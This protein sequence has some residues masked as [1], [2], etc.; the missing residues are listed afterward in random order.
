MAGFG[1][2]EEAS[3]I[4]NYAYEN[5]GDFASY[6]DIEFLQNE[7]E[8]PVTG[9]LDP[10]TVLALASTY[11][12]VAGGVKLISV[13][14]EDTPEIERAYYDT[15]RQIIDQANELVDIQI[16]RE[17]G[18]ITYADGLGNEVNEYNRNTNLH[19]FSGTRADGTQIPAEEA[20]QIAEAAMEAA[21]ENKGLFGTA[22]EADYSINA[23]SPF[24]A[25][26]M[27]NGEREL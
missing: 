7:L 16:T 3:S 10:A 20:Q 11:Q 19:S 24:F 8:V 14:S 4:L 5:R 13:N 6:P 27:K 18:Q 22:S 12:E 21:K 26:G 1:N 15:A 2:L 25:E 17:S 9:E 23:P